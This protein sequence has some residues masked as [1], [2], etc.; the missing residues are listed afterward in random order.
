MSG[1]LA[2]RGEEEDG[3]LAAPRKTGVWQP[4]EDGCL[5][6]WQP[7][8]D[9]CLAAGED[10]CLAAPAKMGV[11]QPGENGCLAARGRWV[12]GSPGKMGVWQPVWIYLLQ[13]KRVVSIIEY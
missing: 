10:G 9:G 8:E 5:A 7:G 12:S 1:S 2:A 13:I 11:W 4:A 3:C 6:A